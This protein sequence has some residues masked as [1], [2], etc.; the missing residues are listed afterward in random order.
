MK[1]KLIYQTKKPIALILIYLVFIIAL[2]IACYYIL[3]DMLDQTHLQIVSLFGL[4][5]FIG[6]LILLIIIVLSQP[7]YKFYEHQLQMHY[8]F[9]KCVKTWKYSDFKGWFEVIGQ[10]KEDQHRYTR[11]YLIGDNSKI[12]FENMFFSDYKEIKEVISNQIP[13]LKTEKKAFVCR[14]YKHLFYCTIIFTQLLLAVS[15]FYYYKSEK[16]LKRE[17]LKELVG[18]IQEAPKYTNSNRNYLQFTLNE[19]PELTFYCNSITMEAFDFQ[20]FVGQTHQNDSIKLWI[21]TDEF[22]K[23]ISKIQPTTFWDYQGQP[24][25]EPFEI[26]N[27][28]KLHLSV[29]VLNQEKRVNLQFGV[30]FWLVLCLLSAIGSYAIFRKWKKIMNTTEDDIWLDKYLLF[31]KKKK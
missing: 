17:D 6:L 11:L 27:G 22:D 26:S 8:V 23:W 3:D 19:Y 9:G 13:I 15:C 31:Q 30:W 12:S 20:S 24:R 14:L 5:C 7:Y 10:N 21:E 25:I 29:N 2:T 16:A 28:S 18:T 1:G 4:L